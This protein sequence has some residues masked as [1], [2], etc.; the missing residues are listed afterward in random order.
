[1]V[2]L[3][4]SR[5]VKPPAGARGKDKIPEK[6]GSIKLGSRMAPTSYSLRLAYDVT[7]GRKPYL[8]LAE[9]P[10]PPAFPM[11]NQLHASL[12]KSPSH[13]GTVCLPAGLG[14]L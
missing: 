5:A 13:L 4:A 6:E 9:Q 1:M 2:Q 7:S 8:T 14:T 12:Q 10:L 11:V 3:L